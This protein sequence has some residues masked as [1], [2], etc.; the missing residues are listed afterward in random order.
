MR[1]QRRLGCTIKKWAAKRGIQSEQIYKKLSV[2]RK[3][4]LLSK[5]AL[6]TFENG[7]YFFKQKIA[8]Q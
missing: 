6:T 4:D 5:I 3:E 8:E 7:D 1:Q 2:Q